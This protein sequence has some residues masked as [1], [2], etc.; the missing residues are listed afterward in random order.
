MPVRSLGKGSLGCVLGKGGLP[1]E[2]Q[3]AVDDGKGDELDDLGE[4][5]NERRLYLRY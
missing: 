3:R 2:I 5:D 1:E 4:V